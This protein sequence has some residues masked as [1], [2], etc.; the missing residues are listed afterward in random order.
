VRN[1]CLVVL[2]RLVWFVF[3]AFAGKLPVVTKRNRYAID[4]RRKENFVVLIGYILCRV[5]Q[6]NLG[7]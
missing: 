5:T 1:Y 2:F 4:P 6:W 7:G 3:A